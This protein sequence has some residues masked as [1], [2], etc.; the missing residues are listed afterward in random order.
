MSDSNDMTVKYRISCDN[1]D[2]DTNKVYTFLSESYWAKGLPRTV[3]EKA[4]NHSLCFSVLKS[5]NLQNEVQIGFA[6]MITDRATFAYLADVFI[7]ESER[8]QGLSKALMQTIMAH[9]DLQGLR[10]MMLATK[11]AH[12]LYEQFGFTKLIDIDIFMQLWNPAV[13]EN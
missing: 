6:R 10:R 8:G 7:L 13:Y 4:I 3:F 11:D 12:G 9:E 5:T 2:I 1:K